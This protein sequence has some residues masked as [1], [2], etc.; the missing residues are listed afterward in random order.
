M[1]QIAPNL[2][3]KL[4]TNPTQPRNL[5]VRVSG[6]MEISQQQLEAAGFQIRRKL[7]LIKGYAVTG[8]GNQVRALADQPWVKSIEEDQQVRTT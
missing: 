4:D 6:D 5:I 2:K 3:K 1:A 8:P 7:G